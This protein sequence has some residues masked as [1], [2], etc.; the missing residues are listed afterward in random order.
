[1]TP[2]DPD[3][4]AGVGCVLGDR[5]RVLAPIGAGASARV[6][7]ADDVVLRRRVA[8]KVLH[9]A[10]AQDAAFLRRF[11]EEAQASSSLNHPNVLGVYDW[12]QDEVVFLVS[13]YLA[14]GSLRSVLD[15]AGVLSPGQGLLVALETARGL[16]SAHTRG[17]VHGDIKPANLLFGS[18]RRLRI[19]DFGL[20]PALAE[21]GRTDP[22]RSL[23]GAVRYAAPEQARTGRL[24]PACDVYSLALV[25]NEAVSGELP[26]VADSATAT[27]AARATRPLEPHRDL[28]PIQGIVRRAGALDPADR[29]TAS[30]LVAELTI[31][32]GGMPRPDP[33]P[34]ARPRFDADLPTADQTG[35][36]ASTEQTEQRRAAVDDGLVRGAVHGDP[37]P[38]RG[39]AAAAVGGTAVGGTVVGGTVVGGT[40][41]G[42][43]VVG[44]TVVGGD[45]T[46]AATDR[47]PPRW[48]TLILTLLVLGAAVVGGAVLWR[49]TRSPTHAV[50]N[51]VGTSF[52]EAQTTAAEF[53]WSPVTIDV[54]RDGTVAGEVVAT[55]PGAGVELAE[56][57]TL[58]LSVSLGEVLVPV[59]DLAGLTIVEA[60][61]QLSARRLGLGDVEVVDSEDL[62]EGVVLE[63][64]VAVGVNEVEPGSEVDLLVSGGPADRTVPP[65]P[66]SRSLAEAEE[67]LRSLRLVPV[68]AQDRRPSDLVPEGGVVSFDPAAGS[69]RPVGSEIVIVISDGPAP[70]PVPEVLELSVAEATRMLEGLGFVVSVQGD[71]DSRVLETLPRSGSVEEY[72]A[73]VVIVTAGR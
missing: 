14:G 35:R 55:D 12:G 17:L 73:T 3:A 63:A 5:Y 29:P 20:A 28:G 19:A 71:P 40:A 47:S 9:T 60:Q 56:G 32:A 36:Q 15:T 61:V 26:L 41:V 44:G 53:G 69:V 43:T 7:V 21:A 50:P 31:A 8:V 51:L 27:L 58:L 59:P 25:I 38:A 67:L 24:G 42:G 46:P 13:E 70:R 11:R 10:L 39:T 23:A 65:V 57:E 30:Q 48:F 16:D 34:L 49:Q 2:F 4:D 66:E 62:A 45:A 72:G 1:M 54:R 33:L 64:L 52:A 6:Y 18:D 37:T 68:T 22:D